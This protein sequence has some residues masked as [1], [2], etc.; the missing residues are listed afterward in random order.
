M[1]PIAAPIVV[2]LVCGCGKRDESMAKTVGNKVGE[3]LTDFASGV[4]KGIDK[5][6]MVKVRLSEEVTK[7]GLSKTISKSRGIDLEEKGI[8]VYF[9]ATTAFKGK[10]VAKAVD[11][12]GQEIGRSVVDVEFSADDAKYV[13]FVFDDEMDTQLVQEYLVDIKR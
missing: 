6:M 10:L 8:T 3:T 13:P 1:K 2:L 12:E 11:K 4:G 5:Q 9:T 7:Q